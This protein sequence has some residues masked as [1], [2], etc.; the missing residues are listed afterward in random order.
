MD[1]GS[2]SNRERRRKDAA[3]RRAARDDA[4]NNDG[5]SSIFRDVDRHA[6]PY[7]TPERRRRQQ[8]QQ[9]QSQRQPLEGNLL[10]SLSQ[11]LTNIDKHNND[12]FAKP[13][14]GDGNRGNGRD[15]GHDGETITFSSPHANHSSLHAVE[16]KSKYH[17]KLPP[18][19]SHFSSYLRFNRPSLRCLLAFATCYAVVLICCSPMISTSALGNDL[20]TDDDAVQGA[21][22]HIKRG[23][24]F[25]R[26]RGRKQYLRAKR[27][28]SDRLGT[29]KERAIR[30]EEEAKAKARRGA[31][32]FQEAER[33]VVDSLADATV[34]RKDGADARR[35]SALL[36][37]AIAAFDEGRVAAEEEAAARG[38]DARAAG[39]ERDHWRD[40]AE[41]WDRELGR[42][43][44]GGAAVAGS[45]A[46]KGKLPGF[47]V[48]GMHRSGTS[49]LSGLLVK[50]FGYETGGPLIGA[51]FDNEKGFYERIDV[52]LQNDEF[53]GAQNS[54]WSWNPMDFDPDL[55]LLHK[56][57]GKVTFKE[58]EKS[59]RFLNNR[60][61]TLAYLQKDPRM[62]IVLPTW[63]RLLDEKPAVVCTYRHPL[64]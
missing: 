26:I 53:M 39:R 36:D 12:Y 5:D 28:V 41:A 47:V 24:S 56:R 48:L 31:R 1:S 11:A 58:G 27:A 18:P 17:S 34:G 45:A 6:A 8:Q 15:R 62:C 49:M 59:L 21:R 50:G 37:R 40:A 3:S 42:D 52:V 14:V 63:L 4:S 10:S 61:K 22:H 29:L 13:G 51:S 55:A 35:A 57:Q 25:A 33:E 54:G 16:R 9:N 60:Q 2:L 44:G 30:W 7:R 32:D 46:G 43:G 20:P 19:P 38:R 23:A 64:E